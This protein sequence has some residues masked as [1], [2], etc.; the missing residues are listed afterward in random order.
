MRDRERPA[1]LTPGPWLALAITALWLGSLLLI[2]WLDPFSYRWPGVLPLW[3]WLALI[4]LIRTFLQTG[5]FI[6]AH[7]AMHLCLVPGNSLLNSLIGRIALALYACIPYRPCR[8]NHLRH[9]QAPGGRKDPDFHDG[10]HTHP[11]FWYVTFMRGYL[12][13]GQIASLLVVWG[14]GLLTLQAF[15]TRPLLVVALFWIVPLVLSS[16]QLF[17]F[18]TYLPHRDQSARSGCTHQ[19]GSSSLP[20]ALSLLTC[21][22]F[23]YHWEHHHHPDSPWYALPSLRRP[24]HGERG[25]GA[26]HPPLRGAPRTGVKV[27]TR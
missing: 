2:G 19:V 15:T 11:L 13:A 3:G 23:G 27:E 22:H 21:Y 4:I 25:G 20:P 17:L 24:G 8:A 6:V 10:Q 9:H 5:L 26:G 18:G 16:I 7:D 1:I 14:M 12:S